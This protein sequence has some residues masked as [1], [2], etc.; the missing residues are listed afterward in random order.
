MKNG[1]IQ[2]QLQQRGRERRNTMDRINSIG[3]TE[4]ERENEQRTESMS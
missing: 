1:T 2:W 3:N 4:V